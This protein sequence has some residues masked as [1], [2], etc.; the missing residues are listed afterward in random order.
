MF[1]R[2]PLAAPET[3]VMLRKTLEHP[4]RESRPHCRCSAMGSRL[5]GNFSSFG[6]LVLVPCV[7]NVGRALPWRLWDVTEDIKDILLP[8]VDPT[9]YNRLKE[10]WDQ[11]WSEES[12]WTAG[13][14]E[15]KSRSKC[16]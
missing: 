10:K 1:L 14:E 8:S 12:S 5:K 15:R 7:F 9:C 13:Q 2:H 4:S 16:V 11:E 6:V 3:R